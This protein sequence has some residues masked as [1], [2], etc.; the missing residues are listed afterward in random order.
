MTHWREY[1][2]RWRDRRLLCLLTNHLYTIWSRT[3]PINDKHWE[4]WCLGTPD[5]KTQAV[6]ILRSPVE[7]CSMQIIFT[8]T[9]IK[10]VIC[11]WQLLLSQHNKI[12]SSTTSYKYVCFAICTKLSMRIKVI[13]DPLLQPYPHMYSTCRLGCNDLWTNYDILE[14]IMFARTVVWQH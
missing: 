5:L 10:I 8:V 3:P 7:G 1:T 12:N 13:F 2:V 6:L 4:I 11:Q 14:F 9:N